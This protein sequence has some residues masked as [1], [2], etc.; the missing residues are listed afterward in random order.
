MIVIERLF[1]N[2]C[3]GAKLQAALPKRS[4]VLALS[5]L[6]ATALVVPAAS[7]KDS[8]AESKSTPAPSPT[9]NFKP[10]SAT[11]TG[12]VTVGGSPIQYDA[13]A[14]TIVVHPKGWDDAAADAFKDDKEKHASEESEESEKSGEKHKNPT[15]EAS[16]FYVAY[17]KQH[18]E[19]DKR[20]VTFLFNG[21]PGSSTV[22]LH[23]GAFGPRRVITA[24]NSHT[25]AAPYQIVNND[26]SL[27]DASDLV[28]VDAPGTGFSRIAGK[29]KEKEFWGV[30]PDAHAFAEFITAYL[31]KYGRWNSPKYL[32]GESYGTPRA[33]VLVNM[34]EHDYA[35]DLN[36]VMMLSQILNFDLSVDEPEGNPGIDLPYIVALPTY[37]ATAWYHHKLPNQNPPAQLE[38]FLKEVEQFAT[39]DY[40][41]ALAEGATLPKD[42]RQA[43][44]EKLHAYTGLPVS[45][46]LKA[47]LRIDGGE[48][49]KN[50]QDDTDTTTGR[51]DTRFSGP[52]MDPLSKEADYDPQSAAISSAYVSAF[53]DYVRKSLRYGQ[54]KTFK[55]A[56]EIWKTWNFQHQPPG[57]DRPLQQATNTMP[58]LASAM[59]YDPELR[60]FL[61]GGY[62]DLATP[63]YEGWY[64]MH[65]LTIPER[66][67]DHIEYH[68]YQ[69]GHMVYAH[70]ESLKALH[71]D[72]A[73]FIH[74]TDHLNK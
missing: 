42:Q 17:S 59:K 22:W 54:D 58:D 51:L 16:M 33:A 68:Y 12:T 7:K 5:L 9:P 44:A 70:Q 26:F 60:I 11:S 35:L 3:A 38:P 69:S 67:Q 47:N 31:T 14:G 23:M 63:F 73:A 74:S 65:H 72:A 21:G 52:T 27:L 71:D 32:F 66:L 64:E 48:F 18:V 34:L 15:A 1:S 24:D 25:P 41:R 39:Q 13:V 56:I 37:A 6:L 46:I 49:S 29:D 40:A 36:G 43:I 61:A 50:L 45:Y 2:N 28:F 4:V 62:F 8:D 10:E 57:S 19:A 20:P 55:P 53:N 30:D